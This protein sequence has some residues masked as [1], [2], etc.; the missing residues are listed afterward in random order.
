VHRKLS[1]IGSIGLIALILLS[2]GP[3]STYGQQGTSTPTPEATETTSTS[4]TVTP[5]TTPTAKSTPTSLPQ[6]G[7]RFFP[8]TG[9]TVP[10]VFLKHWDSNGGLP[11]F[12]FPISEARTEKNLTDGKEYLVQY[13]ERN[14]FEHH[15]EFAGTHN[16]VLLGLLGAELTRG[17]VFPEVEAFQDTDTKIYLAATRHS[18]AEPFLS[19]WRKYGGLGIFGYPISEPFNEIS[20]T[21]GKTYLVQYFQRNRFEFHPENQPPYDVLLGLLGKDFMAMQALVNAW[22]PPIPGAPPIAQ[23][24]WKPSKPAAGGLFLRGPLAGDGMIIQ[25]YYQDTSRIYSMVND[26]Q[27]T[28]VKQQVEW[29]NTEDPKGAYHWDELDRIVNAAQS[30]NVKVMLS[31]VK[32]PEWAT[33]GKQGFPT[34]PTDLGDFMKGM[35]AHYKGRVAAYEIWNEYNLEGESGEINPGR[36]VEMLKE[37]Y[38]G[39]KSQDASAIVIAGALTP[40]GVNDP[41]GERHEGAEGVLSDP[42][43]LEQMY[44]YKDG[45]IRQYFDVLGSHPYGFNNPPDTNWPDNPNM[46]PDFPRDN[47]GN[48]NYYNRHNSFYFRRIEEQRAI[49][50][51]YGDG[52][53]QMW[54]TE[55]GWCSDFR[56]DGYGECRYNTKE[57]QGEYIVGAIARAKKFYPWMGVM[58][59]WNL[60]F[61]TFQPWYTGP[62]H[63][64]ILNGDWSARPA[65][66]TIKNRPK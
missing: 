5:D 9:F 8:E 2:S 53:K 24:I 46:N 65:Y 55:Y 43:Y 28:W 47:N 11:I 54:L 37:A 58:F 63:F 23:P 30:K 10:A 12:G 60:N 52:H 25:G 26:L 48:L 38:L 4:A 7:D 59:L 61:S 20:E 57:K 6:V 21:D 39:I 36:Y 29:K 22:G 16:E 13:F 18:L 35:A 27:F 33:G 19:Y 50:E 1:F 45:M 40:T 66:F 56:P 31:I 64:A 62:S 51:K 14:R 41:K 42:L 17:R 15:P 32:A 3:I 44:L 34:N 49:M